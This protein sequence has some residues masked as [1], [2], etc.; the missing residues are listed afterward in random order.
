MSTKFPKPK[1]GDVVYIVPNGFSNRGSLPH[2]ETVTYVGRAYFHVGSTQVHL[3]DWA[4][5]RGKG[6]SPIEQA[7]PSKAAYDS[8]QRCKALWAKIVNRNGSE[9][10]AEL[11]LQELLNKLDILKGGL[12]E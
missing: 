7:Y 10:L 8:I 12:G 1:V 2:E 11:E 6:Y 3:E 9:L 4:V 5:Y